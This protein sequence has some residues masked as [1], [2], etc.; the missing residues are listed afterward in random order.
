MLGEML[1][2]RR[3]NLDGIEC[4]KRGYQREE[5]NLEAIECWRKGY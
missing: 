3:R 1:P 4:W 5:R 2:E